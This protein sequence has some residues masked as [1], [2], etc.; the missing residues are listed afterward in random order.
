MGQLQTCDDCILLVQR[1]NLSCPLKESWQSLI[2]RNSQQ[3]IFYF[4]KL[5]NCC[6]DLT[7][8]GV[9]KNTISHLGPLP[10]Q[11]LESPQWHQ[12]HNAN[13]NSRFQFECASIG[14][15]MGSEIRGHQCINSN[16]TVP[17]ALGF[18]VMVGLICKQ[19]FKRQNERRPFPIYS[20]RLTHA[21]WTLNFCFSSKEWSSQGPCPELKPSAHP[22]NHPQQLGDM[23]PSW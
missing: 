23:A 10:L 6:G 14:Y 2:Y 19:C 5:L 3:P 7:Y 18:W 11:E 13:R 22:L 12:A 8:L 15:V 17:S 1:I 16:K 9:E 21:I 4:F 20:V